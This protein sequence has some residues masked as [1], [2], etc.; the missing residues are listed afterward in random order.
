M[1]PNLASHREETKKKK[2]K[3]SAEVV[4]GGVDGDVEDMVD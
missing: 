1:K 4:S 2:E 3:D